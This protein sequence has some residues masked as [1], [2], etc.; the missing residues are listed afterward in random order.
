M[1]GLQLSFIWREP[2]A[3]FEVESV[4]SIISKSSAGQKLR[5]DK[6]WSH[7]DLAVVR[8]STAAESLRF[9]QNKLSSLIILRVKYP[10]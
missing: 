9:Q 5:P 6:L 4:N 10:R 8:S 3:S 7:G 2:A 1:T